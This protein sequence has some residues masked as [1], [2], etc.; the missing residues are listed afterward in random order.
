M[1]PLAMPSDS[2]ITCMRYE[3]NWKLDNWHFWPM[4]AASTFSESALQ[5]WLM[6]FFYGVV[7]SETDTA[8]WNRCYPEPL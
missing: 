6:G 5:D 2:Q 4:M 3:S 7:F 8:L 1:P